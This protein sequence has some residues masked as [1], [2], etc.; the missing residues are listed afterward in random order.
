MLRA[1]DIADSADRAWFSAA[2]R[3]AR[4]A[5]SGALG[6][7]SPTWCHG[8][9][10]EETV[11]CLEC[12][13][14]L[15]ALT[16]HPFPAEQQALALPLLFHGEGVLVMPVTAAGRY[17]GLLSRALLAFKDHGAITLARHLA[18]ALRRSV[19]LAIERT[20]PGTPGPG[21]AGWT[22]VTPP[23]SL[24]SRLSRG[25]DPLQ[26]LLQH[27]LSSPGGGVLSGHRQ[28]VYTPG[29]LRQSRKSS[30]RSLNPRGGRQKSR[31][32]RARRRSLV[33]SFEITARGARV[34]PG[35]DVLL[36]D[37]VLTSGSTLGE[38]YRVLEAAGATVHGAAVIA[39]APS[40]GADDEFLLVS[41][42]PE[43]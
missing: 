8:C 15:H 12:S 43:A 28:L 31:G 7:L 20:G 36:L 39:A 9:G 27:A 35:A 23:P 22:L 26:L 6:L 1:V 10:A 34:L 16:R 17:E 2:G 42:S 24:K 38:L 29:V 5:A 25:F 13:E 37:D 21:P 41:A 4:S 11:F 30:L 33:G 40:P 32:A 18:P 3:S 14:D 19:E